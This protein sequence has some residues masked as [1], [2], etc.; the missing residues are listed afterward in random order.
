MKKIL[1][2]VLTFMIFVPCMLLLSACGGGALTK[3]DYIEAFE[4]VKTTYANY[5]SNSAAASLSGISESDF[6]SVNNNEQAKRMTKAS[7]AMVYFMRNLCENENYE[8]KNTA[9]DCIVDDGD[10]IYDI[11]VG[12]TYENGIIII[13]VAANY[14]ENDYLNYFV[15]EIDYDFD[16]KTLNGFSILGYAGPSFMK[17]ES[18]VRY[19]KFANNDLR[20]LN[21][22]AEGYQ[23][24]AEGVLS[25][26]DEF[27]APAKA[28]NPADYSTEY[29][30]AM[31]EANS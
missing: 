14:R 19:Y 24:F 16:N 30:S 13:K 11:R 12:M 2:C 3:A 7:L 8:L 15:F 10:Y 1:N 21:S 27:L 18:G 20:V 28:V 9:E 29:L 31:Q 17:E 4:C 23:T 25:E 6:E 22:E 5:L 26:L